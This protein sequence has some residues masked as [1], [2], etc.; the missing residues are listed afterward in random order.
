MIN[1]VIDIRYLVLKQY[2]LGK[3]TEWPICHVSYKELSQ[4]A[5]NA[6]I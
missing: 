2:L 3:I 4:S 5:L 6:C 1:K